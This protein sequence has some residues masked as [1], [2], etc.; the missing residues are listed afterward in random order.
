MTVRGKRVEQMSGGGG[1]NGLPK[2]QRDEVGLRK[3]KSAG[4]LP[5]ASVVHCKLRGGRLV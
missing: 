3:R 1:D 2:P 4:R 5:S